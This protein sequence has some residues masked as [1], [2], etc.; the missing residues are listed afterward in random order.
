[1]NRVVLLYRRGADTAAKSHRRVPEAG[2]RRVP[3]YRRVDILSD[4][5]LGAVAHVRRGRQRSDTNTGQAGRTT[6]R[7]RFDVATRPAGML[8]VTYLYYTVAS[9]TLSPMFFYIYGR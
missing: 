2:H 9:A 7:Q 6:G 4:V 8:S 1:M 3:A 5:L